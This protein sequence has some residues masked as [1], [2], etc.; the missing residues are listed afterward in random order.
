MSI[1]TSTP[2]AQRATSNRIDDVPNTGTLAEIEVCAGCAALTVRLEKLEQQVAAFEQRDALLFPEPTP[3][4]TTACYWLTIAIHCVIFCF[5]AIGIHALSLLFYSLL[6]GSIGS[7]TVCHVMVN[8]TVLHRFARTLLSV[9]CVGIVATLPLTQS[10]GSMRSLIDMQLILIPPVS[11]GAWFVAKAMVWTQNWMIIPRGTDGTRHRM[12]ISDYFVVTLIVAVYSSMLR[13]FVDISSL[14]LSD[15]SS[16]AT[17]FWPVLASFLGVPSAAMVAR[18]T[19][20]AKIR[21]KWL[22]GAYLV[23]AIGLVVILGSYTLLVDRSGRTSE[24]ILCFAYAAICSALSLVS[25]LITFLLMRSAQYRFSYPSFK[26]R[27][28]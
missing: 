23:T 7:L 16:W 9:A 17:L 11:L 20:V 2:T 12:K 28:E 25:P 14:D 18:G 19:L 15:S 4:G 6:M 10:M 13:G 24:F 22:L 8:R 21:I 26:S 1:S 27:A 5:T 3:L